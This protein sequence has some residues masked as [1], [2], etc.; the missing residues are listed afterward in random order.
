MGIIYIIGVVQAFFMEF[1]LLNKKNKALP[2]KILAIWMFFFGYHLFS[3]Y[4]IYSGIHVEFPSILGVH[5]PLALLHGPFLLLYVQSLIGKKQIFE[6]IKLLHFITPL[7][8]YAFLLPVFF[9]PKNEILKFV[10]EV[11]PTN[12]PLFIEVY[13]ILTTFSGITYVAWSLL[14]LKRHQKNIG[15]NFSFTEEVNLK[16]LRNL[17]LG[18][19]VLW[20]VVLATDFMANNDDEG[21][22]IVF[23]VAVLFVFLIGYKGSRQGLIFSDG[24]REGQVK[25]AVEKYQKSSLTLDLTEQYL[26]RL[27][28]YMDEKK[29]FL[30]SRLTLP[31]LARQLDINAN[32]LS[33][34]INEKLGQNF[35]D[36]INRYRV[37]EFKERLKNDTANR[38]TLLAHAHESGFSSKSSFNE[39][40]K[41]VEGI[42]PSQFLKSK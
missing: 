25:E 8:Y 6:R 40:F 33:Q 37:N 34:V 15:D 5:A 26:N 42:T 13:S 4:L 29:P 27:I 17:I 11:L 36:F 3:Y 1:M 22:E 19:A 9:L 28:K 12:P 14:L 38:Y 20:T 32:Y 23:G 39:V 31:Q 18:M 7:S 24:V 21:S 41:K 30:E 2:D 35:Y 10:F 16:W